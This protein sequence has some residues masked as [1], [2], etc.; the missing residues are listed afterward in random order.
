MCD[1]GGVTRMEQNKRFL[2]RKLAFDMDLASTFV[3][4][5][6]NRGN[7]KLE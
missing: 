7:A 5:I 2:Q 1:R 4:D 3:E 6:Q